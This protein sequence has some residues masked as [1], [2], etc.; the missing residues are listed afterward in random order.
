MVVSSILPYLKILKRTIVSAIPA[1]LV[2]VG[3]HIRKKRIESTLLQRDVG[4]I[5]GVTE[6]C[7]ANW[8]NGRGSPQIHYYPAI[9][10]FLGYYPFNHEVETIQGKLTRLRHWYG[11]SYKQFGGMFD[12]DGSTV[13]AWELKK[14]AV[15]ASAK[16]MIMQ[17]WNQLPGYVK[18]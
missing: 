14:H 18:Q 2:T 4:T 6:C 5:L 13:R 7:V 3:D 9:I 16:R 15:S 1:V 12:V 11:K 10:A 17:L 8:E